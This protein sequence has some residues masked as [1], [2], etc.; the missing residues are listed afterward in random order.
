MAVFSLNPPTDI[1]YSKDT[2]GR[3]VK[4]SLKYG[5]YYLNNIIDYWVE[6]QI[7]DHQQKK[8]IIF[9]EFVE[10]NLQNKKFKQI[11]TLNNKVVI[12]E[13]DSFF[14]FSLKNIDDT[15]RFII[16]LKNYLI[17][18]NRMDCLVVQDYD[19]I[20]RKQLY[21]MLEKKG[22]KRQFLYKHYTY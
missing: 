20:Q 4:R 21:K 18:Q 5:E 14:L 15:N 12:Q 16:S 17:S 6:E 2:L 10:K 3:N 19:T 7:Y 1:V 9:N 22:F 11:F 13:E 8:R